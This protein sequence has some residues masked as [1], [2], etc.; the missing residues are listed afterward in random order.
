M[1]V[2]Y[3]ELL[4]MFEV[5]Y[6]G[7]TY[8]VDHAEFF[9]LT[10][11][12]FRKV[13]EVP[14]KVE[15]VA[16]IFLKSRVEHVYEKTVMRKRLKGLHVFP[17]GTPTGVT[18]EAYSRFLGMTSDDL[19]PRGFMEDLASVEVDP[20][21]SLVGHYFTAYMNVGKSG[22]YAVFDPHGAVYDAYLAVKRYS[23]D[24]K[25]LPVGWWTKLH[26]RDYTGRASFTVF[27][28]LHSAN[29]DRRV[30]LLKY[31]RESGRDDV[32]VVHMAFL[33]AVKEFAG[34]DFNAV[35]KR[36]ESRKLGD[37]NALLEGGLLKRVYDGFIEKADFG[38]FD[39]I[40]LPAE[41]RTPVNY[42]LLTKYNTIAVPALDL[43]SRT[44]DKGIRSYGELIK[45]RFAG[46]F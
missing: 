42:V 21:H 12:G 13:E 35:V 19:V 18:P 40:M 46:V 24:G 26:Y 5:E 17:V 6:G 29:R 22:P 45:K 14:E 1:K 31:H 34:V 39:E 41:F 4:D 23:E 3:N 11:K 16:R 28:E 36:L 7:R 32:R 37:I 15:V 2:G 10:P 30:W 44:T 8:Y 9:E 38:V 25:V 43:K 27:G 20:V 33:E